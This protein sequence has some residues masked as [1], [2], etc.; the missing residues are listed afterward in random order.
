MK[1]IF[2]SIVADL[3]PPKLANAWAEKTQPTREVTS[4]RDLITFLKDKAD[5]PYFHEVYSGPSHPHEK[6]A[7]KQAKIKG[8]AHVAVAQPQPVAVPQPVQQPSAQTPGNNRGQRK[9][10]NASLNPCRYPCPSCNELHYAFH[11]ST[12]RSMTVPQRTEYVKTHSLCF[13]CLKPGHTSEECRSRYI[14]NVCQGAHSSFLHVH[15]PAATP[16]AP[17]GTIN[18]STDAVQ[19]DSSLHKKKLMMT[20]MA[21]ATGPTGETMSVRALLDSGADVSSVTSEVAKQLKLQKLDA[22]MAIETYGDGRT[23]SYLPTANFVISSLSSP[24]DWSIQVT[25]AIIDKITSHHPREDAFAVRDMSAV[26]GL[27]P[28]DPLFHIPGKIDVLLGIDV[29]PGVLSSDDSNSSILAVKTRFGHAFMG[30]YGETP[31]AGVFPSAINLAKGK[32]AEEL[33][34]TDPEDSIQEMLTRFWRIEEPAHPVS[35]H[36]AEEKKVEAHYQDTHAFVPSSGKYEVTL[37]RN[38]KHLELGASKEIALQ[39]FRATERSLLRKGNWDQFQKVVQE[40]LDLDHA[41]P[42]TSEELQ[43]PHSE[44]YY[45]PMHGVTKQSSSTTKLR[46]V[47]DASCRSASGVSL[48]DTLAVGPMLH[49]TLDKILLRFRTYRVTLSGDISKMYREILLSPPDKQLHRF[50]WRPQVDQPIATYCMNRVTFGVA[51]SPYVAVKTLQQAVADFGQ[52]SPMAQYHVHNSFYVDDLLGG[53][54]S[55]EGALQLYSELTEVLSKGGFTLRKFRS[56][57]SEVLKA[58]PQDLVEPM[59]GKDL[60]DLHSARYP[61]ALGVAWDS[62]SDTMSTA[63]CLPDQ[64]KSTKRG[65]FSDV[66]RTFDVLGWLAPVILPM[67]VLFQKLWSLEV[68]WDDEVPDALRLAHKQWREELPLLASVQLPRCYFDSEATTSV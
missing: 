35:L 38:N 27:N 49:P 11:C 19:P 42:V 55:I 54:D 8:S 61:K 52:D 33:P 67:K 20:C 51:S 6:K 23:K 50:L 63:V 56:S 17:V 13:T 53:S 68:D 12:F 34:P 65:I 26:Q 24:D 22:V 4:A 29:L 9:P 36:T 10:K 25:A 28:A 64:Y 37:P 40:Y 14:C 5:Q 58:I 62:D 31:P 16:A 57:A 46:V 47:F 66:S 48:N 59:P 30:T 2:S 60:V 32:K 7:N 18:L 41:R 15:Q 39:R 45:L 21:K 44:T 3:L 1:Y 43:L